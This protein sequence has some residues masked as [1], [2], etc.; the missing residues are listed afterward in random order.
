M[1]AAAGDD[2]ISYQR[3][4]N[5][6]LIYYEDEISRGDTT[7]QDVVQLFTSKR[8]KHC[9]DMGNGKI[10]LWRFTDIANYVFNGKLDD[11]VEKACVKLQ[12]A[13]N[14]AQD[15]KRKLDL[16]VASEEEE[17]NVRPLR[18]SRTRKSRLLDPDDG[19]SSDNEKTP[20]GFR[21]EGHPHIG[22]KVIGCFVSIG[23]F[24]SLR[25]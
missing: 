1:N 19:T 7:V 16:D 5:S 13:Y 22:K 9:V 23:Y 20:N 21:I 11:D 24:R 4:F 15:A 2:S 8:R 17:M 18:T 3:F 12:A 6:L 25:F 10:D 14:R